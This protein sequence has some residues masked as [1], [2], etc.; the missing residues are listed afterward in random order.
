VTQTLLFPIS[1]AQ[2]I[3]QDNEVR[4]I[5]LFVEKQYTWKFSRGCCNGFSYNE[6]DAITSKLFF[7]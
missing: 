2:A 3:A 6:Q 5:D 4:L 7:G 1:I